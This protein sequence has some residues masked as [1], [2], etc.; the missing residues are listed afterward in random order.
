MHVPWTA[1]GNHAG[2]DPK[3]AILSSK[4]IQN[5]LLGD[6]WSLS[7]RKK[8]LSLIEV[9]RKFCGQA[10]GVVA[11]ALHKELY[12]RNSWMARSN[13]ERTFA[14]ARRWSIA[15]LFEG[16]RRDCANA[17]L[18]SA[19]HLWWEKGAALT[20][21]PG[22]GFQEVSGIALIRAFMDFITQDTTCLV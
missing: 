22:F 17:T 7:S 18:I 21:I 10:S 3:E 2:I 20:K 1:H 9:V 19:E 15:L 12:G 8:S 11:L 5:L 6:V 13:P 4:P 14:V 16:N